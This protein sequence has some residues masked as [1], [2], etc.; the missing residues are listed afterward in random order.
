MWE[1]VVGSG[2]E[3]DR[4]E[5]SNGKSVPRRDRINEMG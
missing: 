3:C 2:E 4:S 1:W 5:I